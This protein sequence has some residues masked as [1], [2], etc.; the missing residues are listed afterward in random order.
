MPAFIQNTSNC[1][2]S[3][4]KGQEI[5]HTLEDAQALCNRHDLTLVGAMFPDENIY[6]YY[7]AVDKHDVIFL[8]TLAHSY[9]HDEQGNYR[10]TPLL[11]A[12]ADNCGAPSIFD[13]ETAEEW[14]N[15]IGQFI[16]I[17]L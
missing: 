1:S 12:Q 6:A 4:H 5:K 3:T 11:Q 9:D 17:I 16:N 13:D 7:L 14:N 8:I 2:V 10:A 15:K